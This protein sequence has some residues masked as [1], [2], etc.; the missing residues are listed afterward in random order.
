MGRMSGK[1]GWMSGMGSG[2]DVLIECIDRIFFWTG[3]IDVVIGYVDR[4]C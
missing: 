2:E 3:W 1:G 4:M